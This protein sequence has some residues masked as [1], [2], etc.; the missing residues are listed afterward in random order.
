MEQ[1]LAGRSQN[2][3]I[4]FKDLG[5]SVRKG[6]SGL[7]RCVLTVES[8]RLLMCF[9][10]YVYSP[11]YCEQP[12][13][14]IRGKIMTQESTHGIRLNRRE[15]LCFQR[16][17]AWESPWPGMLSAPTALRPACTRSRAT[18]P[19]L[20]RRSRRRNTARCA[21]FWMA[22]SSHS[23]AFPTARTRPARTAGFRPNLR[24]R[25]RTNIQR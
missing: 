21:A 19:R 13:T 9:R 14:R 16:P 17:R 8:E 1:P 6:D 22:G 20:A 2:F 7:P 23:R 18:A 5:S 24:R 4:N 15:A 25:G 11:T 3:L 10:E 12:R